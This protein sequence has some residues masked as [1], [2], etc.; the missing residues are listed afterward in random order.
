MSSMELGQTALPEA[1]AENAAN[2][3]DKEIVDSEGDAS[4][5]DEIID[6][7]AVADQGD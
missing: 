4:E 7:S 1:S 3:T 5:V 6:Y 2:K